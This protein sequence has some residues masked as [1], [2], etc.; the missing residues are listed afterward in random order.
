MDKWEE[1]KQNG[2]EH[3]DRVNKLKA[4]LQS[5]K[6][7]LDDFWLGLKESNRLMN[8]GQDRINAKYKKDVV[9]VH[10]PEKQMTESEVMDEFYKNSRF[11]N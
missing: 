1:L 7:T 10:A 5:L 9:I 3:R 8:E 11:T 4:D 2:N 6:I